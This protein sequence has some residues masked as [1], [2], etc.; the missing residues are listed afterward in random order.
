MKK[1][2]SGVVAA[3][4]LVTFS[5]V[6][7]EATVAVANNF[8]GPMKQ[9]VN[10][11]SQRSEHA[12][13]ISTGSTGQLYAQIING[14]PF[15]LFFAADNIRPQQLV[16]QGLASAPM[17]YAQGTLVLW[18]ETLDVDV[19]KQLT[20]LAF[21]YLA[22]A[23]P[24]LAP[25]GVAAQQTLEKLELYDK[26]SNKLVLGKGLNPTYQYI[27]TGNA[28][29][30]FVAKSQVFSDNRFKAGSYW[31][32]PNDYYQPITQDVVMLNAAK[33]NRAASDFLGYLKTDSAQAIMASFG[34]Q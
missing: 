13:Q 34:Y 23:N 11:F 27:A 16:E 22:M 33:D 21:V 12:I 1:T 5:S 24:Q 19:E 17:T 26:V 32:V 4:V 28:Q 8:F 30:G 6:A 25:Y 7:D 9:L 18:S 3:L 2:I 15:D 14:A 20:S 10:D 31:Q 29:L